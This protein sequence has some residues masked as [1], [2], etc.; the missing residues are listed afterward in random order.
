MAYSEKDKTKII[1]DICNRVAKGEALRNVLMEKDMPD[2][3]TFYR[4][5][6]D[7]EEKSL[8]YAHARQERNDK[9]FEDMLIIADDQEEDIIIVQGNEMTNHNVINRSKLRIDTR[10]WM[11]GKLDSKKYGDKIDVTSK[12]KELK[13]QTIINL[14]TGKE[15]DETT[16]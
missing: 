14:G 16:T 9:I 15:P 5:V 3:S 12:D 8:Q 7:S 2:S 11:L 13:A 1:N 10:K 4:W 6:D